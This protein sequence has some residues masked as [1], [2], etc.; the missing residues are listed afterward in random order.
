MQYYSNYLW[1]TLNQVLN[2]LVE[3]LDANTMLRFL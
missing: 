1:N 2:D 3:V